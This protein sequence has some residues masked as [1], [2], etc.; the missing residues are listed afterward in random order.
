M[1]NG[2]I[3]RENRCLHRWTFSIKEAPVEKNA[4]EVFDVEINCIRLKG[5]GEAI[6]RLLQRGLKFSDDS[7]DSVNSRPVQHPA[8]SPDN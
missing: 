8:R 6:E 4:N 7:Y 2:G 3:G 5:I 1:D